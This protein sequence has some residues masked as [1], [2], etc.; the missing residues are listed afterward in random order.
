M[1]ESPERTIIDPLMK[2]VKNSNLGFNLTVTTIDVTEAAGDIL[3]LTHN[4]IVDVLFTQEW[5]LDLKGG[6]NNLR[7]WHHVQLFAKNNSRAIYIGAGSG[8]VRIIV[9][10]DLDEIGDVKYVYS[11][12]SV[13][14]PTGET[15]LQVKLFDV[16]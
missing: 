10:A 2:E 13:P 15:Y 14:T 1:I 16:D 6:G 3:K 9:I 12:M 11:D 5:L 8:D 7:Y 4:E